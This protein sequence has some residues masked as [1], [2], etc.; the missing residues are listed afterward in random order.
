MSSFCDVFV[1]LRV[2]AKIASVGYHEGVRK[3]VFTLFCFVIFFLGIVLGVG[4]KVAAEETCRGIV[5]DNAGN[6]IAEVEVILT[7]KTIARLEQ[8]IYT[9]NGG[10]YL[11][12]IPEFGAIDKIEFKKGGYR[13]KIIDRPK[14]CPEDIILEQLSTAYGCSLRGACEKIQASTKYDTTYENELLCSTDCGVFRLD[15]SPEPCPRDPA[16]TF[17]SR[18]KCLLKLSGLT[19]ARP[20][21][22]LYK[23]DKYINTCLVESNGI[24][25]EECQ[26]QIRAGTP[27]PTAPPL[28]CKTFEPIKDA[29]GKVIGQKC[30]EFETAVGNIPTSPAGLVGFVLR[31]VLGL[32][33]G[34][35]L[36]L[37]IVGAYQM[38]TSQ[39]NPERLQGAKETIT[40]AIVG[41]LFIIF[42]L[43][44]L[45]IIG[46]DILRIPGFGP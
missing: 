10:S 3:V 41:L 35:A 1:L 46:V 39:G 8:K 43:L 25:L 22:F 40:S 9:A 23:Y 44:L 5:R 26:K 2:L 15:S 14:S 36:I 4:N 16:G 33:G 37:I 7:Y 29:S 18:N 19:P 12:Q 31:L 38:M 17:Y 28:P 21:D 42:S 13:T 45:E 6:P 32:S 34:I 20:S 24:P 27:S 11:F 30:I